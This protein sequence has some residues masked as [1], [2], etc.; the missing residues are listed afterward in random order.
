[1]TQYHIPVV[2]IQMVREHNIKVDAKKISSPFDA[3][4][5]FAALMAGIDRECVYLLCLNSKNVVVSANLVSMGDLTSSIVNPRE[6]FKAA[7]L[8]NAASIILG[9]NHPSGDPTPSP[10]DVSITK[11]IAEC[12]RFME[13]ELFDH[14]VIG[15]G[16]HVSL[17][18]RGLFR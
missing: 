17:K 10:E 14:I 12:G 15:D 3:A 11:R 4:A 6:I 5:V 9:H 13:I 1:M 8:S 16:T 2:R 18:E 7:V